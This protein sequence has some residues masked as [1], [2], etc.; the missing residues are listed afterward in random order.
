MVDPLTALPNRRTLM[1]RLEV[2]LE[3]SSRTGTPMC[4]A[5]VDLD[6]FKEYNDDFGHLAGDEMLRLVSATM[7]AGCRRQDLLA[8]FGG[9]EFCFVL[10]ECDLAGAVAVMEDIRALTYRLG[11]RRAVTISIGVATRVEGDDIEAIIDRA[12]RALYEA[13]EAGRDLVRAAPGPESSA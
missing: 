6:H 13:K 5:M 2:E 9:E 12:D 10:T 4:L 7:A 1:D 8:R 11:D 3:R